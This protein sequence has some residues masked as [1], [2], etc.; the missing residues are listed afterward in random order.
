MLAGGMFS[1]VLNSQA[2][3][4][5]AALV[6]SYYLRF[7][8]KTTRWTLDGEA[9]LA[10]FVQDTPVVAAFWHECLPLMPAMCMIVLRQNPGRAMR[11]LVSRHRD[12][13]FIGAILGHFG[14]QAVYGSAARVAGKS[15]KDRA[16][17]RGGAA[18]LRSLLATL[19]EA[20]AVVI[21]PDGPRGPARVAAPGVAQLAAVGGAPVLPMA[22]RTSRRIRLNSWDRMIVPLPWGRGI[23]VCLPAMRVADGDAASV[24]L[25]AAALSQAA[26]RAE[27]LCP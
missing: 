17:N 20:G 24:T 21:T 4:R 6:L 16:K 8:L 7:A 12:G 18:S 13:R 5:A 26:D 10:P 9:N 2:A 1:R 11:V 27:M 23:L 19:A 3:Q 25:I 14:V 22:A 15:V